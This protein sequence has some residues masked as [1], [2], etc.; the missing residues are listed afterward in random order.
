MFLLTVVYCNVG[1]YK[2][3]LLCK[4]NITGVFLYLFKRKRLE[5]N[6]DF[7]FMQTSG[8]KNVTK[9]VTF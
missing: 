6:V 5:I 8:L 7:Y 3:D 4:I 2:V 1:F 9:S